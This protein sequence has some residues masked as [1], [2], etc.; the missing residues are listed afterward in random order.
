M[1]SHFKGTAN[2]FYVLFHWRCS[3]SKRKDEILIFSLLILEALGTGHYETNDD[4]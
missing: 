4:S 1:I 2:L 3:N